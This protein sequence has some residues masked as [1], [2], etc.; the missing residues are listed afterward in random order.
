MMRTVFDAEPIKQENS[1]FDFCLSTI[2]QTL[3]FHIS[4]ESYNPLFLL[5]HVHIILVSICTTH[6]E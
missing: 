3:V 2:A 4:K 6:L 1:R 5:P